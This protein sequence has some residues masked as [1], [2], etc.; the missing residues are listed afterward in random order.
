MKTKLAALAL[1]ALL[2]LALHIQNLRL[3]TARARQEQAMQQRDTAQAAL[4]KANE[5]LERQQQLAAEHAR[6]RAEQL[7]EQQRLERE[8]ADR[9][10]HIRRLHSENE[11][12][13]AWADA[14]M[15]EPVIR[16][17]ERPAL[18]GADAYRQRLR[19]TDA[20][21]ATGQQPTDKRRSQPVD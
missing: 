5:I 2:G 18:T 6:Q 1:I 8:L 10:R 19:D 12:L 16:L 3:D 4:T 17:R 20:L 11:K 13:R 9:T 15:P 14:V 7:A 21:P